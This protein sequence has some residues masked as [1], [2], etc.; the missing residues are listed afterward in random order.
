MTRRLK[1]WLTILAGLSALTVVQTANAITSDPD[2]IRGVMMKTWDKPDVRLVV[3]PVVVS[4][5]HAIAGWS[6]GDMG[7]RA[8]LRRK[9]HVWDVVLC[10]G[11]DLKKADVLTKVGLPATV[12]SALSAQLAKAEATLPSARLALF[13]KFEGLVMVSDDGGHHGHQQPQKHHPH[14]QKHQENRNE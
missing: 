12:A 3:D 14:G 11:D 6:Q 8:L 1:L 10:A 4:G 2:A 5:D 13:S 7:G 9:G